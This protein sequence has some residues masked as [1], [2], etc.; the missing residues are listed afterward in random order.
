MTMSQ[1]IDAVSHFLAHRK[2]LLPLL[3]CAL[4]AG[5]LILR[6]VAPGTWIASNDLLL[7]AGVLIAIVGLLLARVL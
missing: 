5:N 6:L 2:G 3:G 7:H 1:F 4:I